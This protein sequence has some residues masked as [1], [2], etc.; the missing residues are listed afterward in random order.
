M[1]HLMSFGVAVVLVLGTYA[2]VWGICHVLEK[3]INKINDGN[4]KRASRKKN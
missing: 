3:L 4:Y 2:V 1:I